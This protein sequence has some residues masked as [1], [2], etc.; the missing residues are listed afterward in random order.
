MK[1]L[2]VHFTGPLTFSPG[3]RCLFESPLGAKSCVYL[4]TVRR[5]P[6]GVHLIHYVGEASR[7]APRQ[8]E[9]LIQILGLNHGIFDPAAARRGESRVVWPGLWRAKS[10]TAP[11]AALERFAALAPIVVEYV[12]ALSVFVAPLDV[13]RALRRHIE[14][15][16][17][18]SLRDVH[19]DCAAL[20][21]GD[22]RTGVSRTLSGYRLQLTSDEEIAGLEPVLEV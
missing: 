2:S 12:D 4:W 17:A 11:M 14:G 8:R 15:S 19:A 10:P 20:Y 18:R 6:D 3:E 16:I 5:E 7:F 21:P 13:D 22:N 1:T 9:H